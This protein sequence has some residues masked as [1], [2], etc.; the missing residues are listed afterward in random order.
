[1]PFIN[2]KSQNIEMYYELHG[3]SNNTPLVLIDGLKSDHAGWTSMIGDLKS[4]YYVLI[5][6]N[7]GVGRTKY[8][9]EECTID[10]MILS[11]LWIVSIYIN[12]W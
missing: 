9:E 2:L 3:D 5:F 8:T 6:D 12:H 4:N 11:N 1:M 7:R 10:M